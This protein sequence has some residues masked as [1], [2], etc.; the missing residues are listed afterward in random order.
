MRKFIPTVA[1]A[2]MLS[3]TTL[4][5]AAPRK[6]PPESTHLTASEELCL[7]L[8]GMAQ[9]SGVF[10]DKGYSYLETLQRLRKV[11]GRNTT[12]GPLIAWFTASAISNLRIVYDYPSLTPA[13]LRQGT[14]T[15]CL[16]VLEENPVLMQSIFTQNR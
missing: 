10:R 12:Q 11:V 1:M 2:T 9:S 3:L 15:A 6:P 14:E 8:G 4:G 7:R 16:Q 13:Q 5:D